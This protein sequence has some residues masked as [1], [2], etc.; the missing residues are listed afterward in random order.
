MFRA[1]A[2]PMWTAVS[3]E[4]V[5]EMRRTPGWRV[6]AAPT[7][8]PIPWTT[9]K[10]PGGKP[11]SATR[12]QS[13]E[14]ESGDHSAG[15]RITVQPAAS[16]GAVFH[17]ESMNGAFQGVITTAGPLGMRTTRLRVPFDSQTRSS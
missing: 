3:G 4:P 15:L 7:S 8:S 10:T 6:S 9:L 13:S 11:A 12:S 14:Q 16:A 5:N 2:V 1:A 17:V